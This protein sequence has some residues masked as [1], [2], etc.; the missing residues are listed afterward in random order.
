MEKITLRNLRR[1]NDWCPQ[2]RA[3]LPFHPQAR[4]SKV[5]LFEAVLAQKNVGEFQM[6]L[7]N[8]TK[9]KLLKDYQT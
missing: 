3:P 8:T 9:K 5:Q 6:T 1:C 7:M 2:I 4:S